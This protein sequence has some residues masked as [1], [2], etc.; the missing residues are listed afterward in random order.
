M[1]SVKDAVVLDKPTEEKLGIGKFVFSDRYSVFDWGEM[2]D[3]IPDKGKA[4]C[5]ATA[6]FFEKLEELGINSHYL[7]LMENGAAKRIS[8][9]KQASHEIKVK[10]LR[11]VHPSFDGRT[12]DYSA[13]KE[14]HGNYL[15]PLEVI[16]RNSLPAGSSVFKR[17]KDGSL[18]LEDIGLN[19]MPSPGD[20]FEKPLLDV[21][22]KLESSDRYISWEEAQTISGLSDDELTEIK[23]VTLLVNDLITAEA[24][25][26]GLVHEDG[27]IEFGFDE[28]RK[29]ALVD[30]LGTL[31]E[32]RFTYQGLAI[33]K[34]LSRI[35]YRGSKWHQDVNAAKQKDLP[36]WKE[37]VTST[38]DPLPPKFLQLITAAYGNFTNEITG[39]RFF[40]VPPMSEVLTGIRS[41]VEK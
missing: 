26:L 41:F 17:L 39:R 6:H 7:G 5:L 20:I 21:S 33:S 32:C 1:G 36:R 16:F 22:T 31:D 24:N 29:L 23:R 25:K 11:V 8:E 3:L 4:I 34:E 40:E 18:N 14:L 9:L 35:Y 38:P 15:I 13:F 30:A 2:P 19:E 12:Y 37:L 28:N 27:K 10:L